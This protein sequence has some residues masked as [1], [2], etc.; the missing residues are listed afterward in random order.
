M[1]PKGR[2][3]HTIREHVARELEGFDANLKNKCLDINIQIT[4]IHEIIYV[5]DKSSNT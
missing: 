1:V 2:H 4:L 3:K 5:L